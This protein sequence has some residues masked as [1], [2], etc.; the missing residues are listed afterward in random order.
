MSEPR[1]KS[2]ARAATA[3]A[4][5]EEEPPQ[6]RGGDEGLFCLLLLLLLLLSLSLFFRGRVFFMNT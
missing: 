1:A 6:R 3:Q 5:P 2:T 4:E